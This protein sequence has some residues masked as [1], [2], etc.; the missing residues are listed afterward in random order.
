MGM[1]TKKKVIHT[2]SVILRHHSR[3]VLLG[4]ET[5]RAASS[6][7]HLAPS[8]MNGLCIQTNQATMFSVLPLILEHHL[9]YIK[10]LFN[11]YK[12]VHAQSRSLTSRCSN[13]TLQ[14]FAVKRSSCRFS[15]YV[16]AGLMVA[17]YTL[18]LVS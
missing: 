15:V 13:A 10:Q 12:D 16:A 4:S 8:S 11:R 5:S 18:Q 6:N 17:D 1:S 7:P 3:L 2:T 9:L 14:T